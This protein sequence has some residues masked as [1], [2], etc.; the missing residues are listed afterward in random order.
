MLVLKTLFVAAICVAGGHTS[1]QSIYR[2]G[3][4]FS[5]LP[6]GPAAK[7]IGTPPKRSA[8]LLPDT[9]PPAEKIATN[10]ATCERTVRASLKDPDSAKIDPLGRVG[11]DYQYLMGERVAGVNYAIS[12]NAKNS[13]G[14]YT[15]FKTYI[16]GFDATESTLL[17]SEAQ[18]R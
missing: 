1:A 10:L 4:T 16:C 7:Q 15:G 12:V 6:C 3:N 8:R 14:G 9:P 11:P 5:E 2:C 17:F 18:S 13:Y